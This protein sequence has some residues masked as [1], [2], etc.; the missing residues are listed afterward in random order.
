MTIVIGV[1]M[2][3]A[4]MFFEGKS[5]VSI[6]VMTGILFAAPCAAFV[7]EVFWEKVSAKVAAAS[8]FIGI[9]SG[10]I[11]YLVIPD[12]NINYV[13]GNLC[14]LLIPIIVIVAGSLIGDYEFDFQKLRDYEPAHKVNA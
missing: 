8:I 13:I 1:I 11:A 3:V 10:I 14:S 2:A 4:A 6:D 12:P 5:L 7:I 9:A